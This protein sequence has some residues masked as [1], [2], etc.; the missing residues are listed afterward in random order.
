MLGFKVQR[1]VGFPDSSPEEHQASGASPTSLVSMVLA[2]TALSLALCLSC[3]ASATGIVLT[4]G[5]VRGQAWCQ[6]LLLT[7]TF[8]LRPASAFSE[9]QKPGARSRIGVAGRFRQREGRCL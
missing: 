8:A 9:A 7:S 1:F 4:K 5:A 2:T 3:F 6:H